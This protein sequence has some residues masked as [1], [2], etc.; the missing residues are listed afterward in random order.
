MSIFLKNIPKIFNQFRFQNWC[1]FVLSLLQFLIAF[2]ASD[3]LTPA[4]CQFVYISLPMH[5][6]FCLKPL[7]WSPCP[8]PYILFLLLVFWGCFLENFGC[9]T[10]LNTTLLFDFLLYFSISPIKLLLIFAF[11]YSLQCCFYTPLLLFY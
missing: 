8:N 3:N 9:S 4:I 1:W 2:S 10:M 5:F 7:T 11:S 6:F